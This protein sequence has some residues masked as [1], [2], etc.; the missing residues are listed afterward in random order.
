MFQ[1]R[2]D[3]VADEDRRQAFAHIIFANPHKLVGKTI[4][5]ACVTST[6]NTEMP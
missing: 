1:L 2:N 6:N 5:M 4:G 3:E